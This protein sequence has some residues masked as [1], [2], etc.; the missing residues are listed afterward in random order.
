MNWFFHLSL[1]VFIDHTKC[2]KLTFSKT[3]LELLVQISFVQPDQ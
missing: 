1:V 2:K 3:S